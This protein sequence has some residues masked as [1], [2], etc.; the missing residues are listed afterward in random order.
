MFK[1][2]A[3]AICTHNYK[4]LLFS[5]L[6]NIA[7]V[8]FTY[9]GSTSYLYRVFYVFSVLCAAY[10]YCV[11]L[12]NVD[13]LLCSVP[14]ISYL[15]FRLANI[16]YNV[17]AVIFIIAHIAFYICTIVYFDKVKDKSIYYV[18]TIIISTV[19]LL[20]Y[21]SILCILACSSDKKP[22]PINPRNSTMYS[23]V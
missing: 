19:N 22:D 16:C 7:G 23:N 8:S 2:L 6:L 13:I 15:Q 3:D 20:L 5:C 21:L 9:I 14:Y 11:R 18:I 4:I 17:L 12:L 10:N 1:K